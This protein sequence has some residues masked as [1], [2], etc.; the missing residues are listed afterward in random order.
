MTPTIA[1]DELLVAE[2]APLSYDAPP[3]D[4]LDRAADLLLAN[5]RFPGNYWHNAHQARWYP[6]T[7]CCTA[8]S[9]GIAMGRTRHADVEAWVVPCVTAPAT[10]DEPPHPAFAALMRHLGV[11]SVND[12]FAWSDEHEAGEIA[13]E[14]RR[15]AAKLR[16]EAAA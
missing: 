5:G 8:A 4:I 14:L 13:T 7:P 10:G 1:R 12:V 9:I 16:I 6:G 11:G 2:P 3:A 15:C